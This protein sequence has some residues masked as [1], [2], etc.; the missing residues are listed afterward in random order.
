METCIITGYPF[1]WINNPNWGGRFEFLP[2]DGAN[3]AYRFSPIGQVIITHQ[4]AM[5]LQ[6]KNDAPMRRLLPWHPVLAGIC[7]NHFEEGNAPYQVTIDTL[8]QIANNTLTS[9]YPK[10]FEE[11]VSHFLGYLLR[12]QNGQ[13]ATKDANFYLGSEALAYASVEEFGKIIKN[14]IQRGFITWDRFD[15]DEGY[16]ADFQL[17]ALTNAGVQEAT[18]LTPKADP[19]AAP[20]LLVN[21]GDAKRDKLVNHARQLFFQQHA[22]LDDMRSACQSLSMALEPL[23]E[24]M[25]PLF[26]NKDVS[27]FFEIVNDFDV[28]HN[29]D[30]TKQLYHP[31]Q[32]EWIFN[33]LLNT[34]ITYSKLK[35]K[36][37]AATVT[38]SVTSPASGV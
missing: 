12:R 32:L 10:T 11:K 34:I 25:K 26:S 14:L 19:F 8:T 15:K 2:T 33:T 5:M 4:A 31:E 1:S 17:I 21:T 6:A 13:T 18:R 20:H 38:T 22:T 7:R 28:R 30:K 29:K 35:P 27:D 3:I 16:P 36:L 23:R 9:W 24:E 37:A